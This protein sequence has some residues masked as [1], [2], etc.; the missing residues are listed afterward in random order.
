MR[1]SV[2]FQSDPSSA[3][4]HAHCFEKFPGASARNHR[5]FLECGKGFQKA[6][7]NFTSRR[8]FMI[9]LSIQHICH[10]P[11]HRLCFP[12]FFL[13]MPPP[14]INQALPDV[15][16]PRPLEARQAVR[17]LFPV[18]P[19]LVDQKEAY[20]DVEALRTHLE[21]LRGKKFTL[22][23]GH[24]VTFGYFLGNS[25]L[26]RNGKKLEIVCLECAR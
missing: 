2:S 19:K 1:E 10:F 21:A 15:L 5:R 26:I 13:L 25:V 20:Q 18:P 17:R 11:I 14:E 24:K 22:D 6:L 4:A 23:C 7:R 8:F 9:F 3:P 16:P 12:P